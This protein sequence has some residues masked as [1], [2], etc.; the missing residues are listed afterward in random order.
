M[1]GEGPKDDVRVSF[2]ALYY[3]GERR[4]DLEGEYLEV[5]HPIDERIP[6]VRRQPHGRLVHVTDQYTAE[7]LKTSRAYNEALHRG[8]T[9]SFVVRVGGWAQRTC[10]GGSAT[11][12]ARVAGRHRRSRCSSGRCPKSGRS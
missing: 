1:V 10:H 8:H 7:E 4:E 12:S 2:V 3:R 6:R 11:P 9:D 5:Y